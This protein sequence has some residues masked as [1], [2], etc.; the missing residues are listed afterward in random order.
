MTRLERLLGGPGS[1][2][3]R[4]VALLGL[5]FK[6]DTDDV[7]ASPALA[8]AA[9][10][11]A[12]GAEVLAH[13]PRAEDRARLADPQLAV[14]PSALEALEGADVAVVA[15]EWAEYRALDWVAGAA[16]MRGS[17]VYDTRGVVDVE[18]T[19]MAGLRLVR[20]GRPGAGPDQPGVAVPAA[21][22]SSASEA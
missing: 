9:N 10:L 2:A 21:V 14:A 1:L 8:L 7:R 17:L 19:R 6:A 13:D 11:R 4:R 5:A 16:A 12:A 18:A 15:T 3:G 20:L 22:S